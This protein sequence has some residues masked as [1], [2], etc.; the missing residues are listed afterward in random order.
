MDIAPF[1]YPERDA[2]D[3]SQADIRDPVAVERTWGER[4]AASQSGKRW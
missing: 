4:T 2:V 3:V 1:L